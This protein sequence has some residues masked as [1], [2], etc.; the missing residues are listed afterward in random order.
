M[1]VKELIEILENKANKNDEVYYSN[2]EFPDQDLVVEDV[3]FYKGMVVL[4]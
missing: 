4:G 1:T 3:Y 2:T